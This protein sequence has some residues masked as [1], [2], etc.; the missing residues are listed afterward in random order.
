MSLDDGQ[1]QVLRL[2][3]GPATPAPLHGLYLEES[4]RP[5]GTPERPFVYASFV[6]SL[7]GRISLVDPATNTHKPPPA[8]TNPR[9][10]RL[11]QELAASADVL[12][13][14]GR[15]MRDLDAGDAQAGLPVIEKPEFADLLE[16]RRGQGL[17][18]QPAVAMVTGTL[19]LPIPE[20]L[21]QS[22]RPIYV[23]TGDAIDRSQVEALESRGV[24]VLKAGSGKRV[25][26]G[27]LVAALARE[28]FGN[29][30]MIAGGELLNSLI[31]DGAFDRLY[32]TRACRILGG[33]EFDTLLKGRPLEPPVDFELLSL[34]YDAGEGGGVAQ[35]FTVFDRSKSVT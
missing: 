31:A 33:R 3:P 21:L 14:S 4:L 32:L 24:R 25:E 19:D 5:R 29:I 34:C 6:A 18:P 7:D 11:F 28:G 17:A 35:L 10:W 2:F 22:G 9:D 27:A 20:A 8:I 1:D 30:D 16:W 26:G 13:T 15:Y 12:V 23:V